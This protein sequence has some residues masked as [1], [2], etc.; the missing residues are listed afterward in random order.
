MYQTLWREIY[1]HYLF[2][3]FWS[4]CRACEILVPWPGIEP[5]SLALGVW[6]LN[7]WTTREVTSLSFFFFFFKRFILYW[8]IT[9]LIF[10]L[11]ISLYISCLIAS[12]FSGNTLSGNISLN[13]HGGDFQWL[14]IHLP[15]HEM[16]APYMVRDLRSH[17]ARATKPQ[18]HNWRALELQLQSPCACGPQL[19]RRTNCSERSHMPKWRSC[20]PQWRPSTAKNK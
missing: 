15:V 20:G 1:I 16:Q 13:L 6:S 2:F 10:I 19:E 12:C 14:R 8:G 17:I 3:F 7:H 4:P 9:K 5:G 18:C 11:N